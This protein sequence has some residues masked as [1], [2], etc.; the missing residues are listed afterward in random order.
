[1]YELSILGSNPLRPMKILV[2]GGAGFIGSNV[3]DSY[4]KRGH[5]VVVVDNLLTGRK[6]NVHP[7]AKFYPMNIGSPELK[8][9]F[10][11]ERP[12]V[13]NHHAAQVSVP[14]SVKNPLFDAEVNILGL[15]NVLQCCIT[16]R[17]RKI[18]FASTGGAIY[19]EPEEYPTSE[20]YVPIPLSP[21]AITKLASEHYLSFY[22]HEYGIDFTVLRYANIYGPR[23]VPQGEAGVVAIFTENLLKGKPS[24]LYCYQDEP[25]GMVR[26][27][28]YVGDVVWANLLVLER[29]S[30]EIFNIGT[31]VGTKTLEV[32]QKL[33]EI[34]GGP[35]E[36]KDPIPKPA[37]KG[38]LRRNCLNIEK[39]KKILGW[40][41]EI[42]LEEGLLR[43]TKQLLKDR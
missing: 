5:T 16:H 34:L 19:G 33:Y 2:T 39:A 43:T 29:G 31:G 26:D 41:P 23:Q 11:R 22:R 4:I 37:R 13:V 7:K 32:Y 27:Y 12:E 9:I 38:D 35:S 17:V 14:D 15:I 25:E 42:S 28:C 3:V 1:M 10:K 8:E 6:E 24:Y 30:G 36:L 40:R 21:Y 18:I 20:S